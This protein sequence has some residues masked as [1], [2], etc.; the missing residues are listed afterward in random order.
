[1]NALRPEAARHAR[2]LMLTLLLVFCGRAYGQQDDDP[3]AAN[4]ARPTI[5]TPATIT[6]VGYLQFESG[7]LGAWHSGEFSSQFSVNEVMKLAVHPRLELLT[8]LEPVARTWTG[9]GKTTDAGDVLVGAQAILFHGEGAKPTIAASYFNRVYSGTAPDLDIGGPERSFL[10]LASADVKGFHYDLNGF[11]NELVTDGTRRAQ[12]GHTLSV[13][14]ALGKKYTAGAELWH[15]TQPFLRSHAAGSLFNIAY[16]A[17]RNLVFD[18]GFERG[19]T[20]TSTRWQA[21][22][23]VTYLLPHRIWH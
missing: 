18:A 2:L 3:P 21:V 14:H 23:G 15:F 7:V 13:S 20:S 17:R 1:M 6:P 10:L 22:A 12:F 19:L 8:S 9:K 5:A 4:P 16:I 11:V